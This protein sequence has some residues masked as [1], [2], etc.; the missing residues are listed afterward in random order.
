MDALTPTPDSSAAAAASV[1][2][3]ADH[4]RVHEVCAEPSIANHFLAELRD[5]TVQQDSLRFRRNLQRLGE[6]IA[7]K[8]SSQLSYTDQTVRTPLGESSGKL[9]HD[10]PVLATVLRA[11][12]PFHQGFLN[13]FDQSPSAFAAAYRIE[14][15]AQVQ[16]QVDYLSAPAWTSGY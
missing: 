12:L 15:T 4:S 1:T 7:Y 8:I 6:I 10:F 11:G 2:P 13:Y 3:A 5:V 16:V 9:L 14:G